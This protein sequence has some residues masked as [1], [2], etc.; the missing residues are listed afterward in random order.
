MNI[1]KCFH[2]KLFVK[3]YKK[4][5]S[6]LLGKSSSEMTLYRVKAIKTLFHDL[7]NSKTETNFWLCFR[8]FSVFM[9]YQYLS[10]Y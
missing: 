6:L 9:D 1:R 8:L 4:I 10:C 3:S 7:L 5:F 2:T